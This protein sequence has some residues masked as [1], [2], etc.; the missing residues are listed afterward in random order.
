MMFSPKLFSQCW[1]SLPLSPI[2]HCRRDHP[3]QDVYHEILS[4]MH[5]KT[6]YKTFIQQSCPV[7][8]FQPKYVRKTF[9]CIIY[10]ISFSLLLPR[11]PRSYSIYHSWR[12]SVYSRHSETVQHDPQVSI[13]KA[14][15][16]I[17]T[18]LASMDQWPFGTWRP[19]ISVFFDINKYCF[20]HVSKIK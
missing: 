8:D 10:S 11:E 12:P 6:T 16:K 3:E 15:I 1:I 5:Q 7:M 9:N 4:N 20:K 14:D 17:L 13:C 18:N 2:N 19:E